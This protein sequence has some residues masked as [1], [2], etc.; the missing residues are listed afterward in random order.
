MKKPRCG[1]PDVQTFDGDLKWDH[2]DITYRI[3]NYSPDLDASITDDAF[4]RAFQVWSDVTP[5]SFTR[6][7]EGTA[8]IMISFGKKNHGDPYPF[9]GKDG[10]LAHAYPPG[11]GMQGDA[12]FDDDE[13]W[14]LGTGPAIKT[15][16]GNAESAMCK[17]PFRFKGKSYSTCT[18]EGREDG[19][20][21]CATTA[22][23]DEDGKYGFCPSELL[24]TYDGNSHG[25]PCVFPFVFNGKTYTS[26]TTEGR[27]DGYRWCATTANFDKD[28]KYGFCPNRDTAVI[29]GNSEG[30]PCHFPF[31]F[32]GKTYTSCTSEG[33]S[34]GKLWCAKTSSYDKDNKWGFCLDKAIKTYYGN[35][36][37]AMCK[38]PFR[39]EGKSYS[40]CTTEGREDGLPWCATTADFDED[41]KY[42]FCPSELL[43]TYDGNSYGQPCVFPFV[44]NGK[45]YSSCTTEGRDDGYRWCATTANFDNDKKYG[46]CPNRD[47]AVIGGNSEGEPCQF[48]FT[49]LGKTYTSCTSEGRSDGKLWC[50]TTSS[51]DKDNKWGFCLDKAIKTYYGNAESAMCKFPFR[52]EGKSYSTCTTEGRED[53]LPWCAT[54]ADF[55]EDGKYGFCPSELL[56]TYDGNSYGQPCVFPFV[57][58]GKTYSSC[59]TEG[60]NDGYRWCATTANFDKDK[61]YGFCPNRDTAVIG[62]NSEGEP[63]HFP[64]TFLGKTY[65]S[66]TSEGRSDGK[67]WCATT[68]SYD[69]DNKWGFCADKGY[70]LFLVAAHEFGHALG[71]DH[72]NIQDALMYPLYKY[73]ADFSLNEDDIEGIQYLYGPK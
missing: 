18:T 56:Y 2:N 45:T 28:K 48:P 30:E 11:E 43:F 25:Q 51:Y 14:T 41:G 26:C 73:V 34:D 70:S 4:A 16:Y 32:L 22:D 20:P 6:L 40:T 37:G 7:Y 10:L 13:Y 33:R 36:E 67:L 57:F 12:H 39:F 23:F 63:C 66:C 54:T 42:G 24:F 71:L 5:L 50:A 9:D 29:G 69:K 38:F 52:F 68:S 27:D 59:T 72:S 1:V 8:D 65:T 3:L 64:F 44:F 49:F 17:F 46:F 53:G 31:T 55:D 58:N 19:L 62:G 35:A 60:R 47:T 15:Y 21:W 61:K